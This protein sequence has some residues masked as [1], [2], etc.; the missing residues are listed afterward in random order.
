MDLNI[1]IIQADNML[2]LQEKVNKKIQE[3]QS[4]VDDESIFCDLHGD[5]VIHSH[6][7]K[8]R[9]TFYQTLVIVNLKE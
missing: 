2:E 6:P 5:M 4:L 3:I 7:G 1:R 9:S 8:Q